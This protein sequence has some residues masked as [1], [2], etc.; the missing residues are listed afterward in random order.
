MDAERVRQARLS[1][2]NPIRYLT[3]ER[4][5]ACIDQFDAGHLRNAALAWQKIRDRD[6]MIKTVAEKRELAIALLDWEIL[7]VEDSPEAEDHKQALEDFYNNLVATDALDRNRRGGLSTLIH[8]MMHS[9][10]HK[11]AVHEIIWRPD[12]DALTA[13]FRFVPLQFFENTAGSI[14]FLPTDFAAFGEELEEAGWM[15]TTGAGLMEASSIAWLFKRRPLQV[16]L[17][18]CDKFG[19]PGLHGKTPASKGSDEWNAF[20]EA[21]AHYAEDWSLL[22]STG[23]E[24]APIQVNASGVAPHSSLVD[25]MDRAIARL[26][27][28]ADLGTM[29]QQGDATGSNPQTTETDILVA[30]D[31]M[32]ISETLQHYVDA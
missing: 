19:M 25:R 32:T 9:A 24:I 4:L 31:A 26:W 2:V 12:T 8:Q 27:R 18:F 15:V 11:Y 5:A 13:E 21:L 28:G 22:T 30:A 20:R 29:S 7:P 17:T 1:Q 3:P 14:R 10:G 23:T 6:D 16:W